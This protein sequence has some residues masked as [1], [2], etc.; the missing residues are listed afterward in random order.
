MGAICCSVAIGKKLLA[1]FVTCSESGN[2]FQYVQMLPVHNA[3][4]I[5]S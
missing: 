5:L 1:E 3:G 2:S 4:V